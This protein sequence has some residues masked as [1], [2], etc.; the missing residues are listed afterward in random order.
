MR[1]ARFTEADAAGSALDLPGRRANILVARDTRNLAKKG[2]GS[3][4]IVQVL[5]G[6]SHL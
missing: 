1:D 3:K 6:R 5:T 4:N 2:P